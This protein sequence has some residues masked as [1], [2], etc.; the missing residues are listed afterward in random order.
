M[1]IVHP[2]DDFLFL[3]FPKAANAAKDITILV[4]EI[5][6]YYSWGNI[7]P[8]VTI[9]KDFVTI[10]IDNALIVQQDKDFQKVLALSDRGKY[11]E[12]KPILERLIKNN[13]TISEYHRVLGQILSELGDHQEAINVLIDAL[14]WNPKNES[15][16]IMMG[17][18]F[19]RDL[20][21]PETALTYFKEVVARN[22]E[23][24]LAYN[25]IGS[26]LLQKGEVQEGIDFLELAWQKD[27]TFP[28]TAYGL[29]YAYEKY[30]N[31][32]KAFEWATECLKLTAGKNK[33]LYAL[34]LDIVSKALKAITTQ[35][36]GSYLFEEFKDYLQKR[37]G[38]EV[39]DEEDKTIVSTAKLEIAEYYNRN[40]HLI[41]FKPDREFLAHLKMHE[42]VHLDLVLDAREENINKSF[43]STGEQKALFFR[44]YKDTINKLS[45]SGISEEKISGFMTSLFEGMNLQM[46]NTP[47]DLFIEDYLY[48]HYPDLRPYQFASLYTLQMEAKKAIEDVSGKKFVPIE[49]FKASKI[50]NL[51]NALLFRD[52][53]GL[54]MV[55]EYNPTPLELKEANRFWN[56]FQEYRHDKEPG[57]EYELIEH[58]GKDLGLDKYFELMFEND[59]QKRPKNLDEFMASLEDDPFGVN[60]D[61]QLKEKE[62]EA[63]LKGQAKIGTNMAVTM[64]MVD[65][66]KYFENLDQPK[67]KK[68][69]LDIAMLGTQ[70]F[71]PNKDGYRVPSIEGK[72]FSG[73]QILAYYYVSFKLA[74]PELLS[75][76]QLPFDEEYKMARI[77]YDG[78]K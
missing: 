44:N 69:A 64:F 32:Q 26:A 54:D 11:H 37:S 13:P 27:K 4:R 36:D 19:F 46:Y 58:W 61:T 17:N 5:G 1:T 25:N 48:N 38:L 7:K 59:Y 29:A 33:Q 55:K 28:N 9:D 56:E 43:V 67:I 2:F 39:R 75:Q 51:V 68:I 18:I 71:N 62:N 76:L 42:L 6:D 41:K 14:K 52:L 78:G 22:P 15:A 60:V 35:N 30:G 73:Y 65:A 16:L 63:F 72:S 47:I 12:A 31:N 66:L 34:S 70:G 77:M 49:I 24:A 74:I 23:N 8:T 3:L 53:F 10:Q 40:Y 45:K 57:E 21:D 20:K 50:L